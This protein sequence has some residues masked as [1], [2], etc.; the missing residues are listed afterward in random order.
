A[1]REDLAQA[2]HLATNEG[3]VAHEPEIDD[4]LE[5]WT[6]HH[7][8]D[9]LIAALEKA[10]VPSGPIYNAADILGDPHYQA[11][12]MFED[13]D[14][15]NGETVMLPTFAPKLSETPGGTDWIGPALGAHNH[16]VYGGLLGMS[17]EGIADLSAEG[18]I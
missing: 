12:G 17:K 18:V 7:T 10:A 11:R 15:G 3:R 13:A 9:E 2:P 5:A 16:E 1:G 4:A 8:Y 6:R 14:I